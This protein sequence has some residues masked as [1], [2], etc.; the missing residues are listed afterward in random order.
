MAGGSVA[1]E[2]RCGDVDPRAQAIG[3]SHFKLATDGGADI[4]L[5]T[6]ERIPVQ[7]LAPAVFEPSHGLTAVRIRF[8]KAIRHTGVANDHDLHSAAGGLAG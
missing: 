8:D 5:V 4:I 6:Q 3:A 7:C 2:P 1:A